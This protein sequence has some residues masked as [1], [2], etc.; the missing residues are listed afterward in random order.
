VVVNM[1]IRGIGAWVLA[2]A[3]TSALIIGGQGLPAE[4]KAAEP[5]LAA[6]GVVESMVKPLYRSRM[7]YGGCEKTLFTRWQN[8]D[9]NA[10]RVYGFASDGVVLH[11]TPEAGPGLAGIHH[12]YRPGHGDRLFTTDTAE[13]D[14][15]I[16]AGWRDHGIDFYA[17]PSAG[18]G[19]LPVYRLLKAGCHGY[20]VGD[21]EKQRLVTEGWTYEKVA[22]HARGSFRTHLLQN[23]DFAAG[24]ASWTG[25]GRSRSR[26]P[27]ACRARTSRPRRWNRLRHG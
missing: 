15:A 14:A 19:L 9:E 5:A 25:G 2:A 16:A 21:A 17:S 20:A 1:P 12:L 18:E 26:S 10:V 24:T 23:G 8:E 13:R 3:V 4:A 11:I 7:P 6:E 22:F 27:M